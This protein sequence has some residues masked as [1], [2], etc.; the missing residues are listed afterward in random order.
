MAWMTLSYGI[1]LMVMGYIGYVQ[2][3]SKISLWM[4]LAFGGLMAVCAW[5]IFGRKKWGVYSAIGLTMVLAALFGV[6]YGKTGKE[7]P[8]LLSFTSGA[9]LLFL[10]VRSRDFEKNREELGE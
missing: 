9:M 5:G 10:L 1:F 3:P 8:A 6:R 4:G 7:I 2:G